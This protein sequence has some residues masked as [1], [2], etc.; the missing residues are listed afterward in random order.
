MRAVLTTIGLLLGLAVVGVAPATAG[1]Y[2][3]NNPDGAV[4]DSTVV[5]GEQAIFSADCFAPG[6]AVTATVDGPGDAD[7]AVNAGAVG[8]NSA[9]GDADS[10]GAIRAAVEATTTGTYTVSAT[11][12]RTCGTG[13]AEASFTVVAAG[14]GAG[15]SSGGGA[16]GSSGGG[17]GGSSGADARSGGLARTGA[18]GVV[19]QIGIAT[20][21]VLLGGGLVVF[22]FARRRSTDNAVTA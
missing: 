2:A 19:A 11:G 9:T 1:G 10:D 12:E 8:T 17:A 6:T 14:S 22:A 15:G 20:G 4:L 16:G 7:I 18:D 3:G 5:A 21:L 13:V